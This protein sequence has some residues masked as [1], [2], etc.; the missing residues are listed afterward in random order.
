[1]TEPKFQEDDSL[2]RAEKS[3]SSQPFESASSFAKNPAGNATKLIKMGN[4]HRTKKS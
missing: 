3:F 4:S 2:E 1:M